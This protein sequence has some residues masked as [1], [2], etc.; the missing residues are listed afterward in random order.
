MLYLELVLTLQTQNLVVADCFSMQAQLQFGCG[1]ALPAKF[2]SNYNRI[3][4]ILVFAGNR[5]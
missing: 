2:E 3:E 5:C 4:S 1:D